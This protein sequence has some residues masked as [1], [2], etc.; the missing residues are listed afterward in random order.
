MEKK[1]KNKKNIL[2]RYNDADAKKNFEITAM[3]TGVD[4]VLGTTAGAGFGALLGNWSPLAGAALIAIGHVLGDKSGVLRVAGAATIAYGIAKASEN[5]QAANDAS[6]NGV[7]ITEGAKQRLLD[8]KENWLKA[9][10]LDKLTPKKTTTNDTKSGSTI[11]AIELNE[12][13]TIEQLVQ[14][15]AIRHEMNKI[16]EENRQIQSSIPLNEINPDNGH[17]INGNDLEGLNYAVYQDQYDFS[18]M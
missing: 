16:D 3:K 1:K 9:F 18:N 15:A 6:V 4:A 12:L 10:H 13:N 8:F 5:R 17:S 7:S 2:Q 11:G 14:E